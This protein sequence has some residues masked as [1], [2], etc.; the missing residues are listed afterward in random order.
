MENDEKV[1]LWAGRI[2]DF[3][4]S[5]QTIKDWCLE[6]KISS[7]TMGYWMRK[8]KVKAQ[9]KKIDPIFAKLPTEQEIAEKIFPAIS[10]PVQFFLPGNIRIEI[11]DTCK[12]ELLETLLRG[13]T[14]NA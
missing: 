11:S 5:G 3:R 9:E 10:S 14:G 1:V 2:Q 7:S 13:L 12:P 4:S 6:H 8:L